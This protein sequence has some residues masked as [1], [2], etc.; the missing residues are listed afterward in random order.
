[1]LMPGFPDI[2]RGDEAEL[3][4]LTDPDNRLAVG[5][6]VLGWE[7]APG[8]KA[9]WTRALLAL[10]RESADFLARATARIEV[11]D[12]TLRLIR[13]GGGQRIV[14]ELRPGPAPADAW[15]AGEFDGVSV[16]VIRH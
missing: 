10:R 12:G 3:L 7:P 16:A 15:K 11:A 6:H 9:E 2:Y 1:M 5:W 13:E 14:V 8:S 4:S